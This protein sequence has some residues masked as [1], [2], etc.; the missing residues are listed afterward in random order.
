MA[1]DR[2]ANARGREPITAGAVTRSWPGEL[3]LS[4]HGL[5]LLGSLASGRTLPR[6]EPPR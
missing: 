1:G 2:A 6:A 3:G 4:R 5:S